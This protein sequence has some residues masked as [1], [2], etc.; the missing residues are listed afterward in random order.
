M[1]LECQGGDAYLWSQPW[2]AEAGGSG[3]QGRPWLHI[4]SQ[5]NQGT[6]D[7]YLKSK[8]IKI[9]Q[10]FGKAVRERGELLQL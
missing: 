7:T 1:I 6:F 3:V 4:D 2:Q 10:I 8:E 9:N 5:A